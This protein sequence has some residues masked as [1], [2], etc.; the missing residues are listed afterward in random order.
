MFNK[1]RYNLGKARRR[2]GLSDPAICDKRVQAMNDA[3]VQMGGIKFNIEKFVSGEW[4]AESKNMSGI[5][6]GGKNY[7]HDVNTNIKDAVF[8]YFE[9]PPELCEA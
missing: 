8:T 4:T 3:I 1:F 6:T 7:P 2:L 9:I 5:I